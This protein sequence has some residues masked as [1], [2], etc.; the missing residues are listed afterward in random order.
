MN[1][2]VHYLWIHDHNIHIL[3]ATGL[4]VLNCA[5][6]S[7]PQSLWYLRTSWNETRVCFLPNFT[8][9]LMEHKIHSILMTTHSNGAPKE[10]S[11][12]WMCALSRV[13]RRFQNATLLTTEEYFDLALLSTKAADLCL[14]GE[15]W[16]KDDGFLG[17][18]LGQRITGRERQAVTKSTKKVMK[19][20]VFTVN[21]KSKHMPG[22]RDY[23]GCT[24]FIRN[25]I[26]HSF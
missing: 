19:K 21:R 15:Q 13:E 25:F 1:W 12:I 9:F 17:L 3:N 6:L 2:T 16:R 4:L 10:Q 18:V 11:G 22:I 20:W 26:F 23:T 5:S 7:Y 14:P 8:A 24:F